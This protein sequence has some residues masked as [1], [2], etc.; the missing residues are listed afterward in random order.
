MLYAQVN[1]KAIWPLEWEEC[2]DM[3]RH[4]NRMTFS[5]QLILEK[6]MLAAQFGMEYQ[7]ALIRYSTVDGVRAREVLLETSD[8]CQMK[9][10]LLMLISEAEIA[11]RAAKQRVSM[12]P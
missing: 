3:H 12:V 8:V 5:H 4:L 6:K 7:G 2:Q 1:E 9:A 10:A 11:H